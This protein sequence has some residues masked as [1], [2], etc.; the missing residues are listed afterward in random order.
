MVIALPVEQLFAVKP[1]LDLPLS[2]LNRVTGMDHV[3]DYNSRKT[4]INVVHQLKIT[5]LFL[6]PPVLLTF[7]L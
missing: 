2:T 6:N 3:P 4:N 1:Q 7:Y 5:Y